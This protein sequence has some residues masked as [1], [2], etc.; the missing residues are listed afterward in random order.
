MTMQVFSEEFFDYETSVDACMA[1]AGAAELSSD[2]RAVMLKPNLVNDSP[3]PVT[4]PPAFCAAVINFIRQHSDT[5]IVIAEGCGDMTLDTPEIFARTGYTSMARELDVP[6]LDLN[7]APL[8]ELKN[9]DCR[10][11]PRMWLP[12]AVFEHV[13]ISLPVLKAHSLCRLTGSMKNMMGLAPPKHY[14]DRYG[15]WKKADFHDRLDEAIFDLNCYRSP[16][17]TVM[18]ATVGLIDYHLGGACC[19]PPANRILASR[20]ARALD[21]AAAELLGI[22]WQ[23]VGHLCD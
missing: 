6:L 8:V 5:S 22:N 3:H 11:F 21:R 9:A 16:D 14:G 12:E 7:T 13:L 23:D 2:G 17:F 1:A 10:R 18:D 4:T 15:S 20:D 19:D